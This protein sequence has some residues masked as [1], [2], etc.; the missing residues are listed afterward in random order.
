MKSFLIF[1]MCIFVSTLCASAA[2]RNKFDA[3]LSTLK[4]VGHPNLEVFV[5]T[6]AISNINPLLYG[7]FLPKIINP[8]G[9]TCVDFWQGGGYMKKG[10]KTIAFLQYH[11]DHDSIPPNTIENLETMYLIV[12]YG[13]EGNITDYHVLAINDATHEFQMKCVDNKITISQYAMCSM[14]EELDCRDSLNY[15]VSEKVYDIGDD[16][17]ISVIQTTSK[18]I[19]KKNKEMLPELSFKNFIGSFKKADIDT[20][21]D[22]LFSNNPSEWY[23]YWNIR[24]IIPDSL[25]WDSGCYTKNIS[26]SPC[27]CLYIHGKY[28]LFL[29]KDCRT[30]LKSLP[31]EDYFILCYDEHGK[32]TNSYFVGR[33]YDGE[34]ISS[35]FNY[36]VKRVINGPLSM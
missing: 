3:F 14:I 8:M 36:V 11:I 26:W 1:V 32:C 16:G 4:S 27:Q 19:K 22:S 23:V 10:D 35:Q 7:N 6:I 34:E 5:D 29:I 9:D 30:P 13:R 2:D 33:V 21:I 18:H 24:H 28:V 20:P 25:L 12:V 31:Y 15:Y 17:N